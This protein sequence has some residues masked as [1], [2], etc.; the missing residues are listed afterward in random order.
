MLK[1]SA[2]VAGCDFDR[3][4]GNKSNKPIQ[5]LVRALIKTELKYTVIQSLG[6]L[7]F[8]A[9]DGPALMNWM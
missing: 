5:A 2:I 3:F 8:G 7:F 4:P 6:I 9:M 1:N